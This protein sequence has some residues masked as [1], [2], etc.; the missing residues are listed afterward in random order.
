V[1]EKSVEEDK[2]GAG[3]LTPLLA[4]GGLVDSLNVLGFLAPDQ[5]VAVGLPEPLAL[6]VDGIVDVDGKDT[7]KE[8]EDGVG[9]AHI[10][11]VGDEVE[12][13]VGVEGGEPVEASPADVETEAVVHDVN[14]VKVASLP[15]EELGNVDQLHTHG[16]IHGVGHT[17]LLLLLEEEAN[18]EDGPAHHPHT[19][20][21][22]R[23]RSVS[24]SLACGCM[25]VHACAC[26]ARKRVARP[27]PER[28][29][30]NSPAVDKGLQ[31]E[32]SKPRIELHSP[33][34]VKN[35]VSGDLVVGGGGDD[36]A[37]DHEKGAEGEG[38]E[39]GGHDN[40]VEDVVNPSEVEEAK[41]VDGVDGDHGDGE[42]LE[43]IALVDWGVA[44]GGEGTPV[45]FARDNHHQ[46]R[47]KEDEG[48]QDLPGLHTR[49]GE[50]LLHGGDKAI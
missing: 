22:K 18:K 25:R 17:T 31:V 8:E 45:L 44:G 47:L 40:L 30:G 3:A 6:L 39:A 46:K 24:Q 50:E 26:L 33:E 15:P 43:A 49:S 7:G 32:T 4:I 5:G 21:E 9:L 23:N 20:R 29:K 13:A 16:D 48:G 38:E 36:D 41:V 14:G 27:T 10:D 1:S 42:A 28:E 2:K 12:G 37:L 34:K 35:G 19:K 11:G